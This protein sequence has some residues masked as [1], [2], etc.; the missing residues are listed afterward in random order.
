MVAEQSTAWLTDPRRKAA[1]PELVYDRRSFMLNGERIFVNSASVHYFRMP[2]SEWREVLMK[3]KL[4]GMNCIDTYFAWNVHEPQEGVWDF[5]GDRDC[6][7]FLDLCAEL[8]LWVIARPGPFICAEWDFGGYPW[9]L[10]TKEGIRFRQVN[11]TY[12]HY[13]DLYFDRIVP[14]IRDRQISRSGTVILVQVENEYGYLADDE[15]GRAHMQYLR[16][17]LLKRG[18]DVPLITCVGGTE[19][20]VEGANFWSGA[21]RHYAE[22][23]AKQPDTPKLVTEFWTGWFEH[24]G[25][26]S[27]TQKTAPLLEKRIMEIVR[28]G[29][30]GISHYMFFGGTN[31]GGY[32]GRTV[33]AS[34]I[35]MVTSYDYD[36]PLN[37]YGRITEKYAS[38]KKLSYFLHAFRAFLL[39]AEA[40][41]EQEVTFPR[42]PGGYLVR[43]RGS[44]KGN[45]WFVESHQEERETVH[46]TLEGG[47]TVPVSVHP[48]EIAPVLD[49][50]PIGEAIHLTSGSLIIGNEIVGKEL[51]LFVAADRGQRSCV[52]IEAAEPVAITDNGA[53]ALSESTADGRG[54]RLDM[55]HFE[56]PGIIR[57]SAGEQSIRFVVLTGDVLDRTWRI[58][59]RS[60][61]GVR[62]AVGLDDI[63]V[64]KDGRVQGTAADPESSV[65]LLGHWAG[66]ERCVTAGE[67]QMREPSGSGLPQL[68]A[69]VWESSPIELQTVVAEE[70]AVLTGD[71]LDFG[72]FGQDY[73]YLLYACDFDSEQ[74]GED[75][76]ILPDLQDT[77]R[78]YNNGEEQALVRQVGA[79]AVPLKTV[80][81]SN[82][83]QILVQHMGR[84]N[85][86]PYL[87]ET[88]GLT[89]PV[90]RG[91]RVL[92]LR[93][94][95]RGKDGAAVHLDEVSHPSGAPL[96]R[97]EFE[98][99][100]MD[101]AIIAGAVSQGL[102]ING[103]PVE[104]EGY[105]DW[106]AFC[107]VDISRY[108]KPGEVNVIEMPYVS[109]PLN[110]LE[111]IMF[112]NAER[113]EDWSMAGAGLLGP[114][115]WKAVDAAAETGTAGG[116]V[117][118]R[119]RFR[120]PLWPSGYSIRLKLRL[121][122]M[123]KGLI[124]L[125]G[126][127]LGRFW[128]I[129]P[130][131]DY[132][133]PTD[134][135]REEN[136]LLL[137]DEEG[138][139]PG[140]VRLMYDGPSRQPWFALE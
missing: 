2:R 128:Q 45:M 131:E 119:W 24:W 93:R 25:G 80:Q 79:A 21:D 112:R 34:D 32:G 130:Q 87:G 86:S 33:G 113:L 35:Y 67:L 36:A 107:T 8:G 53:N 100:A 50:I 129:G 118:Y 17:G 13:T 58:E 89:G 14:V 5:A 38:V 7:A 3:A 83:L 18:I 132:K 6:G 122:G 62:Y 76:L 123:S 97:K 98:P 40:L 29:F 26:P 133:V 110:R 69:A 71:P 102:R 139:H 73:G 117:W 64:G 9:W 92:D 96:V 127:D 1:A 135:L 99:G 125:N 48:G 111:L 56:E 136:E 60:G 22:L 138:R 57:I 42:H 23:R 41:T 124:V 61:E 121:T 54:L 63:D 116:P 72:R 106:F 104:L 44:S 77:A 15:Q 49:R 126:H 11:E 103:T 109:S 105:H 65:L 51:T 114:G 19:G 10:G 39:Q 55:C 12:L 81:G 91:G 115:A 4:A 108:L 43:G 74:A 88:K 47:V 52:V 120:R 46:M 66:G 16:N 27:A 75:C 90:Y 85:F 59:G 101:R 70:G 37:E 134:W 84:L 68:P 94:D 82:R 30:T 78:V 140:Q 31:F 137:F 28:A 20:T 95:W